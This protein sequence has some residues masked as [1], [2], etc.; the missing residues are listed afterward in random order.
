MREQLIADLK[1]HAGL[2]DE[3]VE[4][5]KHL[6]LTSS[7]LQHH[8][9][10]GAVVAPG[11]KYYRQDG[12]KY[13]FRD[14]PLQTLVAAVRTYAISHCSPRNRQNEVLDKIMA[15]VP[16]QYKP[17][18]PQDEPQ[19]PGPNEEPQTAFSVSRAVSLPI[20]SHKGRSMWN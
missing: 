19:P 18:S 20:H 13:S 6:A 9:P 14:V 10:N 8:N 1:T 15:N 3:R 11:G 4:T 16:A 12:S 17:K 5:F 7:Y 2:T